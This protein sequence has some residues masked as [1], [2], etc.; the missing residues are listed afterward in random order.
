MV[1]KEGQLTAILIENRLQV[2]W[3]K[4]PRTGTA[5]AGSD[6]FGAGTNALQ[7]HFIMLTCGRKADRKTR[8]EVLARNENAS[9]AKGR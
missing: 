6:A 1:V 8:M 7:I 4:Y 5:D 2:S 3:C 9:S